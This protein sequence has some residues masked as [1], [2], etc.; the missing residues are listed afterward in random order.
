MLWLRARRSY[1]FLVTVDSDVMFVRHGFG[2]FLDRVMVDS[3]Y[4]AAHYLIA[5]PW[6]AE[7]DRVRRFNYSWPRWWQPL[8]GTEFGSWAFNPGSVFRR[9]YTE[10]LHR[11][12][13]AERIL[14]RALRSR[15]YAI[16]EFI[17]PSFAA[18]MECRPL[19]SPGSVALSDHLHSTAS[20]RSCLDNPD[21]FL[22]HKMPMDVEHPQRQVLR[23]LRERRT[24][25]WSGLDRQ[26]SRT[27]ADPPHPSPR[28]AWSLRRR[29]SQRGRDWY[30]RFLF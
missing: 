26:D 7:W 24:P 21:V 6:Y 2:E 22:V 1:E 20:F 28:P 27:S 11:F 16:E 5:G 4:M 23:A 13:T 25:D 29:L 3:E 14:R 18:A 30:F 12:V 9:E 8:F 19:R 10:K 15:L 17:W